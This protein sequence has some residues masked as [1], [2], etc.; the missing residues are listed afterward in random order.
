MFYFLL[1]REKRRRWL[2]RVSFNW[3]R[4]R[5]GGFLRG[6]GG[7]GGGVGGPG[8]GR[9]GVIGATGAFLLVG[10]GEVAVPATSRKLREF[11]ATLC[12]RHRVA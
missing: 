2:G 11:A 9:R 8:S 7:G 1:G 10:V 4:G 5:G 6:G 3:V 12:A